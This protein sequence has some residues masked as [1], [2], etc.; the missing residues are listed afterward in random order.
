MAK[1]QK[2]NN[3]NNS[4]HQNS[5]N[6][7][8]LIETGPVPAMDP[9]GHW[10][11]SFRKNRKLEPKK[12]R[13]GRETRRRRRRRRRRKGR[14]GRKTSGN[15]TRQFL[16]SFE[17]VPKSTSSAALRRITKTKQKQ[18]AARG[19][20]PSLTTCRPQTNQHINKPTNPKR[21]VA[22]PPPQ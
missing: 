18:V 8:Q 16:A 10:A 11:N 7:N 19:D 5:N 2:S 14:E 17:Q 9:T 15:K 1:S 21:I 12:R 4:N 6:N 22:S 20:R 3:N 13:R